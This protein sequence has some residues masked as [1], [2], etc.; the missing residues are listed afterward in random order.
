MLMFIIMKRNG[1]I[2]SRGVVNGKVKKLHSNDEFSS[3]MPDFYAVKYACA[4]VGKEE[5]DVATVDLPGFFL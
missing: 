4:V 1:L 5:R 3:P 2:K